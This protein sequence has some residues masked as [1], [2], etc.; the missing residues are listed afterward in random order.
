PWPGR[1][2]RG[3]G[4][5]RRR[6]PAIPD[7]GGSGRVI[8]AIVGALAPVLVVL[9]TISALI[10]AAE[11]AIIAASRGRMHQL[12]RDGDGA[13]RRVNRLLADR[14]KFIGA[15]GLAMN[16]INIG[17]SAVT[18]SVMGKAFPG[19]VG[20]VVS[21]VVMTVLVIFWAE[22]LPKTIAIA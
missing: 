9:L 14:E 2:V 17:A 12:E 22:I 18:G 21:T 7:R 19:A 3:Q 16:A 4:R 8:W 11:T 1:G 13:A 10:S 6:R 20:T 15:I 5:G